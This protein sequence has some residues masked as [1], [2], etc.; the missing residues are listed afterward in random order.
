ME[1][2]RILTPPSYR[3]VTI[4]GDEGGRP[5]QSIYE[6]SSTQKHALGTKLVFSDGRIF[7]YT[8]NGA[9][10]LGKSLMCQGPA[11][12]SNV[13]EELQTTSGANVEVG[14]EEIIVDITTGSA[15]AENALAGGV[16]VVNKS[17]GIGDIYGILANKVQTTDTL[18]R[19]LLDTPIRNAFSATTEITCL[20]NP[21]NGAIVFPTSGQSNIAIGVPLIDVTIGYYFWAQRAG[22]CP[23]IVDA[24]DTIVVGEPCGRPGTHGT[25]GGF[26]LV[27]NDGT[28]DVWGRVLYVATAGEAALIQLTLE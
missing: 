11:S 19:V 28:D 23:G 26:G 21:Y 17:T 27:A 20:A 4:N 2:P 3:S 10:A 12:V 9:A 8:K 22:I 1:K 6:E 24:G 25:A 18:M 14:D 13:V 5:Y 15:M 16:L 7:R